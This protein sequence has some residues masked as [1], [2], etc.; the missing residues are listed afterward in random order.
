MMLPTDM[1]LIEDEAFAKHVKTYAKDEQAFFKDFAT[2]FGKLI[3]LGTEGGETKPTGDV[4]EESDVTKAFR[5]MAM[6]GNLIRMKELEGK[7]DPNAPEPYTNRT[8]LH[9]ASY[10]GHVHVVEYVLSLGGDVT[11]QDVDGDTPLH[12]AVR[13]GHAKCAELLV[14]NGAKVNVKNKKGE[15]PLTM[16]KNL[17]DDEC[18]AVL[19]TSKATVG[20]C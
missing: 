3:A 1:A 8:A 11:S 16:A 18:S 15:T 19:K 4:A 6:H 9:K 13:L 2:A 14:N 5:E 7:P 10:F 12:D 20:K 17:D